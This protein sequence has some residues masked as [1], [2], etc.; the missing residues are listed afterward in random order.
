MYLG[1]LPYKARQSASRMVDLPAPV[2]PVIAKIPAEHKGS[3]VKS[4]SV[5]PS[6]EA[7]FFMRMANIFILFLRLVYFMCHLPKKF[8]DSFGSIGIVFGSVHSGKYVQGL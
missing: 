5:L 4:I 6:R 8:H 2:A 1:V 7:R 3:A